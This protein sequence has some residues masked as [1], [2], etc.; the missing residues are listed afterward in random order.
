[1]KESLADTKKWREEQE[2]NIKYFNNISNM[3]L[4]NDSNLPNYDDLADKLNKNF[5]NL[6]TILPPISYL[7]CMYQA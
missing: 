7:Y 5:S 4:P 1:M 2:K 3:T 6:K